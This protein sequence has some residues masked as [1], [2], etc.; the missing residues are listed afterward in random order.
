MS[1]LKFINILLLIITIL[2]SEERTWATT[3][4]EYYWNLGTNRIR[5][6]EPVNFTPFE[7]RVGYFTYGGSDYWDNL[8]STD[9]GE[10]SPVI[11]D[12]TN[13]SF[14]YLNPSSSRTLAFVEFDFMKFN[15]PNF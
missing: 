7:A 4:F 12:S 15:L 6:R 11:L 3:T 5:F 10:I 1:H 13:N 9:L 14:E 2:I 8:K